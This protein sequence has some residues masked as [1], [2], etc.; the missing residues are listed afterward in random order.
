VLFAVVWIAE[1]EMQHPI[2][3]HIRTYLIKQNFMNYLL[4]FIIAAF[5]FKI[6]SFI[7]KNGGIFSSESKS[8]ILLLAIFLIPVLLFT[9]LYV[10]K[11]ST[12]FNTSWSSLRT[13]LQILFPNTG[14]FFT[15]ENLAKNT[16]SSNDLSGS[17]KY[18]RGGNKRRN[19]NHTPLNLPLFF[20]CMI[21]VYILSPAFL[22]F[23]K[24]LNMIIQTIR[25]DEEKLERLSGKYRQNKDVIETT[26]KIND[27]NKVRRKWFLITLVFEMVWLLFLTTDNISNLGG[28]NLLNNEQSGASTTSQGKF[29]TK[30]TY[31]YVSLV[32]F[33]LV[34]IGLGL[35]SFRQEL[36]TKYTA[37]FQQLLEYQPK[38]GVYH[39]LYKLQIDNVYKDCLRDTFMMVAKSLLPLLYIFLISG[40][41][42]RNILVE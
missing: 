33:G 12:D 6:L 3:N 7:L 35:F 10:H 32:I 13:S 20:L 2:L 24:M 1:P 41:L 36:K 19:Y 9:T 11:I 5:K 30:N 25:K 18:T 21:N 28:M 14:W 23:G 42:S 38:S 29:F 8:A 15:S 31:G 27:T 37:L 22:K 16:R 34:N 17:N 26:S 39:S 4:L 40:L